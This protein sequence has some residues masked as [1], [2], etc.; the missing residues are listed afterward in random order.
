MVLETK[1]I[2]STKVAE[3]IYSVYCRKGLSVSAE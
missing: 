3:R 2:D 1:R